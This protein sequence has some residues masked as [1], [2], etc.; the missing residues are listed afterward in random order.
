[1]PSSST[2]DSNSSITTNDQKAAKVTQKSGTDQTPSKGKKNG[3]AKDANTGGVMAA[4]RK[5][6]KL[7]DTPRCSHLQY[8]TVTQE[9]REQ[10]RRPVH[11]ESITR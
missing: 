3:K 7:Y 10:E 4:V 9:Q 11:N 6:A 2:H 1:M 5:E 8:L